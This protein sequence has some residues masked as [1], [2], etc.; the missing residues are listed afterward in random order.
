MGS[1]HLELAPKACDLHCTKGPT[2]RSDPTSALPVL[3]YII[4]LE[5]GSHT[6]VFTGSCQLDSWSWARSEMLMRKESYP[7]SFLFLIKLI[8]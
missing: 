4:F 6:F 8:S 5:Q 3:K 1:G 7:P 2:L